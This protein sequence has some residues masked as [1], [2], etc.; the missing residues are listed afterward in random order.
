MIKI[1]DKTQK[2]NE[3]NVTKNEKGMVTS[4]I[5]KNNKLNRNRQPLFNNKIDR[6][7]K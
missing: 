5:I 6:K 3:E 2:R 7:N 1:Q 4:R